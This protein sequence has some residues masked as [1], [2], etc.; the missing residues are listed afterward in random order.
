MPRHLT[1]T[2]AHLTIVVLTVE[3]GSGIIIKQWNA[4]LRRK[5]SIDERWVVV[6]KICKHEMLCSILTMR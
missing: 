2:S 1:Q 3:E 5:G 6:S 4:L